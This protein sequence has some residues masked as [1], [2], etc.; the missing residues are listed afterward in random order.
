M[1]STGRPVTEEELH[2]YVD[3]RLPAP[4]HEEVARYLDAH[5]HIAERVAAYI[6]QRDGLREL[7]AP[8]ADAPIPPQLSLARIV[9][10][11]LRHRR[12]GLWRVA[13]ALVLGLGLGAGGA[14]GLLRPAHGPMTALAEDAAANAAVYLADTHRPVELNA[15]QRDEL[16][17]W[18]AARLN[19]P[20]TP[21]D[22]SG[23]GYR[24]LGGRVVAT[25]QGPA[26]LFVYEKAQGARLAIFA[27][28]TRMPDTPD[29]Q[30]A[31]IGDLDGCAWVNNGIGY[32]LTADE[33]YARLVQLSREVRQQ[34]SRAG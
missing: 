30:T 19:R 9:E 28:P 24:L 2:A 29:V 6:A 12:S 17:H 5:P 22:L 23:A 27:R 15:A 31:D 18:V 32:A 11:R 10:A 33:P 16:I 20:I 13:A 34:E 3:D 7:F 1:T 25:R 8:E 4:R 21:P 26:A 14:W